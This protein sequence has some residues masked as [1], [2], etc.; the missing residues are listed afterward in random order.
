MTKRILSIFLATLMAVSYISFSVSA[1]DTRYEG[2][3]YFQSAEDMLIDLNDDSAP[4]NSAMWDYDDRLAQ[5]NV[6]NT[7]TDAFDADFTGAGLA[8][9]WAA[10]CARVLTRDCDGIGGRDGNVIN[11]LKMMDIFKTDNALLTPALLAVKDEFSSRHLAPEYDVTGLSLKESFNKLDDYTH[12]MGVTISHHRDTLESYTLSEDK[13]TEYMLKGTKALY[14]IAFQKKGADMRDAFDNKF[15]G[16]DEGKKLIAVMYGKTLTS[17]L[18]KDDIS[19]VLIGY[20]NGSFVPVKNEFGALVKANYGTA[21]EE[22]VFEFLKNTV[23]KAYDASASDEAKADIKMLFG[24]PEVEGDKGALQIMFEILESSKVNDFG[25]I[26]TWFNLFLRQHT[27]L[28]I[29]GTEATT[30][31][32]G[33]VVNDDNRVLVKNN[34]STSFAVKKLDRYG[35]AADTSFLALGSDWLDLKVYNED[36]TP[37][38]FVT[39]SKENARFY[40]SV[41]ST[42]PATYPAYVQLV[43]NDGT[44]IETYPITI[45]N[46]KSL[47]LPPSGNIK[48]ELY[49]ISYETDGGTDLSDEK[50]PK[51][52]KV[53]INKVPVKEGYLFEGWYSDP[54]FNNHVTEIVVG[55]NITLYAKWVKDNGVAGGSYPTPD[56]LNGDDHFAYV[57]GYPD[58]LVRPENNITRAEVA[59]IFFRLLKDEVREANLTDANQFADVN[60]GD[61]YNTAISTLV[62]LGIVNGRTATEFVPN[63]PITRAEFATIC[64]RFDDS[65]YSITDTFTDISE[66][67]AVSYIRESAARGWIR[68]YEDNTFRPD[69]L[70]T[71]A[72][73]M[74]LINR[75]LNRAPETKGDLFAGMITWGDNVESSWYYIAVQEATNS[76]TYVKKNNV[77]EKWTAID[78]V[79]DWTVYEK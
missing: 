72:E 51:E 44:Y 53:I 4:S 7:S 67:W 26:N 11:Y 48:E 79:T 12:Q 56:S 62:K 46:T 30:I 28:V 42:K 55:Q 9:K 61:W 39:Y 18:A 60:E 50:Y 43:R 32:A 25:M 2:I 76:H 23:V 13:K 41:D 29:S 15:L 65:E 19:K 3:K 57:I 1:E 40:V 58:G 21:T 14:Q 54:E 17:E 49:S 74:T 63:A 5:Q 64:A 6:L 27:Q 69:R 22:K 36:H 8:D 71:R 37:N 73:T 52:T 16:D 34:Y 38:T 78:E 10:Y 35:I 24:D 77:Y 66:H 59:S 47:V 68:G 70:I 33:V 45:S 75:V 31:E 20:I